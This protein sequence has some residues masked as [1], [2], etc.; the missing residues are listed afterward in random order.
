MKRYSDRPQDKKGEPTI[1]LNIVINDRLF[2]KVFKHALEAYFTEKRI[3]NAYLQ[4]INQELR[5]TIIRGFERV[6]F[7]DK[8]NQNSLNEMIDEMWKK[9][10][11]ILR[12]TVRRYNRDFTKKPIK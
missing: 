4:E 12:V 9:F 7:S 2:E 8:K 6:D 11:P 5:K 10:L 3:D 1:P